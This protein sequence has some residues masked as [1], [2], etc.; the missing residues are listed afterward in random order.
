MRCCGA[1]RVESREGAMGMRF[2]RECEGGERILRG[3]WVTHRVLGALWCDGDRQGCWVPMRILECLLD[4]SMP[5]NVLGC[6]W[7]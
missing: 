6:P 4:Y 2:W 5:H 7:S 3:H 1:G